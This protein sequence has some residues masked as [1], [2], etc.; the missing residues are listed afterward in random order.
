MARHEYLVT[1][2]SRNIFGERMEK[3]DRECLAR[4]ITHVDR[5]PVE[6]LREFT[7]TVIEALWGIGF[8]RHARRRRGL[9]EQ[10][11]RVCPE[12][13]AE[14]AWGTYYGSWFMPPVDGGESD[15]APKR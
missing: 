8:V 9:S 2:R 7:R 6:S 3:H 10:D 4:T 15:S 13:I 11:S 12:R 14:L 5:L 1:N